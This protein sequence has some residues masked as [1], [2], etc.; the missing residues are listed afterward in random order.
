LGK[1]VFNKDSGKCHRIS[2]WA[3]CHLHAAS[4]TC[5][6]L[7]LQEGT[8]YPVFKATPLKNKTKTFFPNKCLYKELPPSQDPET[9]ICEQKSLSQL[10]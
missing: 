6:V 3:D 9:K 2:Q 5:R 1:T 4:L 7:T 10:A 8:S